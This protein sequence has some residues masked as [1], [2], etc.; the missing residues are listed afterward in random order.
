MMP[1]L[2]VV[3]IE[4]GTFT[5]LVFSSCGGKGFETGA[6]IEKLTEQLAEKKGEDTGMGKACANCVKCIGKISCNVSSIINKFAL[7]H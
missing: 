2:C 3:K 5:P 1:P 7:S 6:F 4:H